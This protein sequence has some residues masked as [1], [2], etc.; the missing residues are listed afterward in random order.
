MRTERAQYCARRQ[1]RRRTGN[2]ERAF[3]RHGIRGRVHLTAV[4]SINFAR[5]AAQC[6]YYFT[7]AAE[8]ARGACLRRAHGK[9]R[10]RVRGRSRDAD[11]AWDRKT[12]RRDQ[13]PTTF[14]RAL[15]DGVYA[16]DAA[17]PTLSPSM[18]IQVASNFERALFE[19]SGRDSAWTRE[20]MGEF[21]RTRSL[22]IPAPILEDLRGRYEA[23]RCD[24][25]Q[26]LA[27]IAE[28]YGRDRPAGRPPY[29]RRSGGR[30]QIASKAG[31]PWSS[32]RP[33]TLQN[34]RNPW[35]ARPAFRPPCRRAS[36]ASMRG[37][38]A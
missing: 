16:A 26:T 10:R 14:W 9:F 1:F 35:L 25:A 17:Q 24:D 11:G 18:D 19:A 12:R 20:A 27:M 34:S 29:G 2:R 32:C 38:S 13:L 7:A 36:R 23:E 8:V 5:I 33:R 30:C 21:A 31:G 3:R 22:P 28:T 6:V 4:N 37:W 15:N